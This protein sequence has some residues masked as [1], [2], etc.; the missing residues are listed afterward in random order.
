MVIS[1][2]FQPSQVSGTELFQVVIIGVLYRGP[3]AGKP[4]D[5][6]LLFTGE[7]HQCGSHDLSGRYAPCPMADTCIGSL[8]AQ[9]AKSTETS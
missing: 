3:R 5:V 8:C 6:A 9:T 2:L 1:E 7:T 4:Y